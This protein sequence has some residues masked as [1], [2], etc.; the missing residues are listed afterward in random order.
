MA[1]TPRQRVKSAIAAFA[2]LA[3]AGAPLSAYAVSANTTINATVNPAISVTTSSTVSIS[4]TPTSASA[5]ESSASDTVTVNTNDTAG[6]TLKL[7]DA[8]TNTNLVSGANNLAASA[9][10]Y[11]SPATLAVNTWGYGIGGVGTFSASY[12]AENNATGSTLKWAGM[13]SSASP[14]TIKTTAATASNDVTTVWYGVAVNNTQASAT[15]TPYTDQVT[16]TATAN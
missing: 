8:D 14:Q 15:S 10:T 11:A 16:Y 1:F 3:V 9:N 12:S 4:L 2:V 13:P 5:V 7:S 6:Y